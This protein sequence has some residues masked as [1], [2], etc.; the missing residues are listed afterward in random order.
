MKRQS[1][2]WTHVADMDE[3]ER[4]ERLR[5]ETNRQ[6][7]AFVE[8]DIDLAIT[9]L[10]LALTELDLRNL[11]RVDQLLAKAR[12]AYAATAKLLADVADPDERQRLY[13]EHQA[14]ADAKVLVTSWSRG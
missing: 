5:S 9:F 1:G 4:A 12:I 10:R 11:V 14:L 3:L 13:N 6:R 7:I 2:G 8:T